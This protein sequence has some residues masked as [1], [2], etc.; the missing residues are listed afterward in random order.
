MI[1]ANSVIVSTRAT[2]G[3]IAINRV[4]I[5]T[6]QGFKNIIIQDLSQILMVS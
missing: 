3:R 5:A 6:N 4:P 2:I 1:P